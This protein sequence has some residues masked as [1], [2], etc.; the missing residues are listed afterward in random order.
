MIEL[1]RFI[2]VIVCGTLAIVFLRLSIDFFT[3][4]TEMIAHYRNPDN[5]REEIVGMAVNK[6]RK[7]VYMK[8][9]IYKGW[10]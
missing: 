4:G 5:W 2:G 9:K 3:R 10:D 6:D 8:R 7:I 1:L